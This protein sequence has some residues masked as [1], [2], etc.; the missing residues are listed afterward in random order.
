MVSTTGQHRRR[1]GG[2]PKITSP[3]PCH[4]PICCVGISPQFQERRINLP[5]PRLCNSL[6]IESIRLHADTLKE[7]S[8]CALRNTA[9]REVEYDVWGSANISWSHT[10][11]DLK[12][13]MTKQKGKLHNTRLFL[14]FY[15]FLCNILGPFCIFI[16]VTNN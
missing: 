15:L 2:V 3:H 9:Y 16:R 4:T 12:F 14:Y 10:Q 8:S 6:K 7:T 5:E 13:N 1:G 11:S